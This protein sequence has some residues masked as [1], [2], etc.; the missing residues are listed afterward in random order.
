MGDEKGGWLRARKSR[1]CPTAEEGRRS[2]PGGGG[3][4]KRAMGH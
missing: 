2:G 1:D 3:G 4:V